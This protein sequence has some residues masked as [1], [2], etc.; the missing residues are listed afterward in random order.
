MAHTL[1]PSVVSAF[2]LNGIV[3]LFVS[4]PLWGYQEGRVP[5]FLELEVRQ[6]EGEQ[7]KRED[8]GVASLLHRLRPQAS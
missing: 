1:F 4:V 5:L 8:Q 3:W 7:I 6:L 2:F